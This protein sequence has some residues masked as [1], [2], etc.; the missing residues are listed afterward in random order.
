MQDQEQVDKLLSITERLPHLRHM[1][2]DEPRGL[3]DYDHSKL[4]A[5][6][7]VI[8][9]GAKALKDPQ[10]QAALANEM[11]QGQGSDPVSYTHLITRPC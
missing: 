4:H 8:A 10:A 9:D 2:Y 1:L 5:I 7:T 3:R 6:E 11:D